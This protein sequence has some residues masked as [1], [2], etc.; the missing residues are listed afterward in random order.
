MNSEWPY[1][2]SMSIYPTQLFADFPVEV[3]FMKKD[4]PSSQGF[5]PKKIRGRGGGGRMGRHNQLGTL[6]TPA[7]LYRYTRSWILIHQVIG[8]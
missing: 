4:L 6:I 1:S 5:F 7:V 3:A 8:S 2:L